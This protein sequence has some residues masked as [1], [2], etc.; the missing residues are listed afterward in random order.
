MS[1]YVV[2]QV[3][4]YQEFNLVPQ[5]TVRQQRAHIA[6]GH[7]HLVRYDDADEKADGYLGYYDPLSD[8]CYAWPGRPTGAILDDDYTRVFVDDALL[9]YFDDAIGA[10]SLIQTVSGHAN[11]VRSATLSFAANGSSYPHSSVFGDRGVRVG[12]VAK[13]VASTGAQT[14]TL[15]TYVAGFAAE[16]VDDIIAAATAGSGNAVTQSAPT[17]AAA[18]TAGAVNCVEASSVDQ[19]AYD[20]L[21]DGDINETY[22]VEVLQSSVDGDATAALLR[23]TSASGND[24][25]ASVT[26]ADFGSPT[27]IGTRGLTVTWTNSATGACSLTADE[28]GVD[29][30]DLIVGQT[31]EIDCGQAYT[32]P[33][34]ASGGDYAGEEDCVY[35]IEVTR[36]GV[37]ADSPQITVSTNRGTDL[38]GP[39]TVTG[40]GV[41][42]VVG[43]AGVTVAFTGD[44]LCGGDVFY[45]SVTA[46][47]EGALKTILLGHNLATAV[48]DAGAVE[49]GL[50]LYIRKDIEVGRERADSPPNV[51][52][53]QSDTEFCLKS[54]MTAYD[55]SWTVS[56]VPVALPVVSES[57]LAY[58]KAY[59]SYRAWLTTLCTEV[60]G[61]YD[62]GQLDDAISGALHPDNPL[63]WGVYKALQNSN[64]A[65]VKYTA[66]C[67]PDD[68]EEWLG[69]LEIL[70][71]RE[72][73]YG[74]VPLTRNATV[75]GAYAAHV[76]AQSA[77]DKGRWRVA[78]FNL[79]VDD[80]VAAVSASTSTDGGEVLATIEDDPFTSGTQYT[81]LKVPAKNGQFITNNVAPGDIVRGRYRTD[82]FGSAT[83]SE[84][85]VDAVLNQDTVR[86][87]AGPSAAVEVAEKIEV[88]H[89]RTATEKAA[90]L[91]LTSGYSN[92]RVMCVWPDQ[93]GEGAYTFD[94]YHLCAAL[95]GLASG[96]N[97]HQALTN[98]EL[99]GFDNV[100]RTLAFNRT[101]LN[102]M[103]GG[104]VWIVTQ[105]LAAGD[106]FTRHALTTADYD[107][108]NEREESITRNVDNVSFYFLDLFSPFIGVSNVTQSTVDEI[109]AAAQAGIMELTSRNYVR[110]LGTQLLD[111]SEVT[112]CRAH[113]IL[114]DRIVLV[115]T[116]S[117]PYALNNIECHLVV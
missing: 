53:T 11:R 87:V 76:T 107:D 29:R 31:W 114:R 99:I 71:G 90:R 83:Y 15:W 5:A 51:N 18:Q 19:S 55:S 111:G 6:G 117:V 59:V 85:L 56:G 42:T 57:S 7:A 95:A 98:V 28:E 9:R 1:V 20:G 79:E 2:P 52:W 25:V 60:N 63:K 17:A 115:L 67:D 45:I 105:D 62:V 69:V 106:I 10:G 112:E 3:L 116:L 96:V 16:A 14:Y 34:V 110:R 12:D 88:W 94:G 66:V 21:E 8:A 38:S 109:R 89:T 37:W 82:G 84:W 4:V 41:A 102:T 65:E 50:T 49:V 54:G 64:G 68:V 91:A 27:A 46:E 97:P 78:W 47:G 44:A 75:L 108:I 61:I 32:A 101:Q 26:P 74:L 103:A 72:D 86:L 58:G 30:D 40:S 39:T 77:A 23:V 33:T 48:V 13:V 81:L 100:D 73:V 24:D 43:T 36:G 35:V 113:A 92:R 80:A 22:T 104:G 93:V 70:D